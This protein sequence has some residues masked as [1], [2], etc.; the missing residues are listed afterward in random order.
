[1]SRSTSNFETPVADSAIASLH[2]VEHACSQLDEITDANRVRQWNLS[3][4]KLSVLMPIY[5]E[6]W[7][8]PEILNRVVNNPVDL[9][10]EVIAV[11]DGSTDGTWDYLRVRA[12][13]DPRIHAI[14]HETN[15]GKGA[16]I[17]SA[18]Q[19][20]TGD[21]A[22]IQD[23]DL[24]YDPRDYEQMLEPIMQGKADAVFGSRF[25]GT[26]RRVLMFWHAVANYGLTF[27][28]NMLNDLNLTDMSTCYKLVRV[29]LLKQ[30]RLNGQ[31]FTFDPELTCRLAQW[32]ARIYEVPIS[33][34]GR[35]YEEGKKV[36]AIDLLKAVYTLF[37]CR[38][39]DI[40]FTDHA[41]MFVLRSVARARRYNQWLLR[42]CQR[43]LGARVLE[44]G[45]G[46][47]NMSALLL[48]RQ[49]LVAV[50]HDPIYIAHLRDRWENRS[51]VRTEVADLTAVDFSGRWQDEA[52][53]TVF[54][55]NVLEHLPDDVQVLRSFHDSLV[56]GGHCVIVV[57]AGPRLYTK[58]D[59]AL[60][61][62]RRYT[63]DELRA[64][65]ETAG[66]QV[67][68]AKRFSKFGTIGWWVNGFVMKRARITPR[69]MIWFDR[70][71]PFTK[72][73]DYCLPV[74]GMS[75][76]MVGKRP[77]SDEVR[78]EQRPA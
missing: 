66:L 29:N 61:H 35:S 17:Q 74:P 6:R 2:A 9:E 4:N 30:L 50:D 1:V 26:P 70:L 48:D 54:C 47:G 13:Q 67:V 41:G 21:V 25:A 76:L 14:R 42:Q 27:L 56:P 77:V 37:R 39:F 65:M 8:L 52:L 33:Y 55:S 32:G 57:P 23:A 18:I 5:N 72:W 45:A 71:W 19:Q 12:D 15:R 63:L 69:Q 49:R 3:A 78:D 28:S 7:T 73:L 31:S 16:A 62:Y 22:I 43:F 46:I 64:K 11:D 75:L 34:A 24:E 68:H 10:L 38:F 60:G 36:R 51:N 53:D 40:Q 58:I 20:M 44:A 59:T